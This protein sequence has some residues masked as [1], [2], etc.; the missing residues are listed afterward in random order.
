MPD[1][2]SSTTSTPSARRTVTVPSAGLHLAALSSR[3]VIARS[4]PLESPTTGQ[5]SSVD[6]EGDAVGATAYAGHR[7]LHHLGEVDLGDHAGRRLVAGQ[8]DQVAD[9]GA[10][11]L[12]LAADVV[13]QL[14]TRLGGQRRVALGL[15]EQVEVGAQRGERRTQLVARVGH[16]PALPVARGAEREQHLVERRG[17]A[18]DLVVALDPQRRQVLGDGDALDRGGEAAYGSQAVA[19]H[20][21][22]GQERRQHAEGAEDEEHP[23]E[24]LE[25]AVVGRQ[26]LGEDQRLPAPGL[27]GGDAEPLALLG[28]EG[29]DRRLAL[30]GDDVVLRLPEREVRDVRRRTCR[31][32]RR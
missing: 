14:E 22:A 23:A 2:S 1:P 25:R 7:P 30:P 6:V 28:D 32:P 29:A 9:Q 20:Q 17:E 24:L 27:H 31:G 10:Q 5:G 4:R 21:P 12:D 13:E 8:L 19:G 26:R 3:L 16:Q 15:V 11:L 18:G